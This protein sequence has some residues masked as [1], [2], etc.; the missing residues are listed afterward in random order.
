MSTAGRPALAART[1]LEK[2]EPYVSPQLPARYRLNTNESPYP[3]PPALVEDVA[4]SL[5]EVALN[6]YPDRDAGALY[7]ALSEH[8][9]WPIDGLWIANGSNEVFLHVFLTFGGAGRTAMIFEPTYALHTSIPRV[10]GTDVISVGRGPDLRIGRDE[11]LRAIRTERPEVVI[12]TSPNNPSG[13]LEERT[14]VEAVVREA[15]GL[16]IVDEAY[17]E[18]APDGSSVKDLLA[19]HPNLVVTRTF[20]KAW[21]LAGVRLG[22]LMAAPAIVAEM[23]R[24]RLPYSL[25]ALT[26]VVGERALEH[27]ADTRDVVRKVVEERDR[28]VAELRARSLEPIE[29][30]ANFVM[31][32]VPDASRLW[33]ALLER[34]VLVRRYA[35]VPGLENR[36]RVSAGLP[37][38]TDAFLAALDEV[39]GD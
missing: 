17:V 33:D 7:G 34:G 38:E 5:R 15:A 27:E 28:I 1:D 26:Q 31:F 32:S 30:A 20:S 21:R 19:R 23:A 2:V 24:V 11:A 12:L 39:R 37:A 10:A 36:L 25:S 6:R 8:V 3:P 18:F 22:Y 4:A 13:L 29:S 14:T 16:V 35:G 9:T